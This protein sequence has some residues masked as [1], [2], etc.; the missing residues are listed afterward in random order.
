MLSIVAEDVRDWLNKDLPLQ[1]VGL[2][3]SKADFYAGNLLVK[4]DESFGRAD[5]PLDRVTLEVNEDVYTGQ[6]D[7]A[8]AR[9]IKALRERG[10][11]VAL[12]NFGTG[13]ASLTNLL[14]V[15]VDTIKI[16]RS[17][18]AR[19]WPDD[20]SMVIVEGLIDIARKLDILVVAEGIETDVQASQL[21]TMGC[22]LGQGFAFSKAVDRHAIAGLLR[23]HAQS[24]GALPL[25]T[26][27]DDRQR[28]RSEAAQSG[29]EALRPTG[30]G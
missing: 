19:L 15:P 21:W 10:L 30:T 11:R 9:E 18:I 17:F 25:H 28:A 4:L 2:N 16:D 20:P 5:I 27:Q 13:H 22:K 7:W 26:R 23:R 6:R 8:V 12:D 3:I 24:D 1:R 29:A 14:T